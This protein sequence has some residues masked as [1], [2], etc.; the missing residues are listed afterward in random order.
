MNVKNSVLVICVEAI[1]YLLLY[2]LMTE[3]LRNLQIL[4]AIICNHKVI[5]A[6]STKNLNYLSFFYP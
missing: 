4:M 5:N 3:P 6:A 1:T 2:I